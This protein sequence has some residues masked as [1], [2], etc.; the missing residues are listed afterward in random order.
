LEG[1]LAT[2][3]QCIWH[4]RSA[5]PPKSVA[6]YAVLDTAGLTSLLEALCA[7]VS[8]T[9]DVLAASAHELR[10]NDTAFSMA[11]HASVRYLRKS[12]NE[13]VLVV[14]SNRFDYGWEYNGYF[15]SECIETPVTDRAALHVLNSASLHTGSCIFGSSTRERSH[16]LQSIAI[17]AGVPYFS[18]QLH[19]QSSVHDFFRTMAGAIRVGA[20]IQLEL[21]PSLKSE[22]ASVLAQVIHM[23]QHAIAIKSPTIPLLGSYSDVSLNPNVNICLTAAT[24]APFD[25]LPRNLLL[26]YRAMHLQLP[27]E[28]HIFNFY[29]TVWH[30]ESAQQ[31]ALKLASFIQQVQSL[32]AMNIQASIHRSAMLK[33]LRKAVGDCLVSASTT[34]ETVAPIIPSARLLQACWSRLAQSVPTLMLPVSLN[35]F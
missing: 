22:W 5:P 30:V 14:G 34:A 7:S 17:L 27:D 15:A 1:F 18:T 9:L 4:A 26:S 6:R 23:I 16:T 19:Q 25:K 31:L 2:L 8:L 32:L 29:L 33:I 11:W 13:L 28:A 24:N 35:I 12:I 21:L 3:T 20:W 10:D